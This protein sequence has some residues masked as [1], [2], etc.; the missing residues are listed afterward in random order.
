[1]PPSARS[2]WEFLVIVQTGGGPASN[3][4]REHKQKCSESQEASTSQGGQK[5]TTVSEVIYFRRFIQTL[6][7]LFQ[8]LFLYVFFSIYTTTNFQLIMQMS[9]GPQNNV[10]FLLPSSTF[11]YSE[12]CIRLSAGGSDLSHG[13]TAYC[14]GVHKRHNEC[15]RYKKTIVNGQMKW[16]LKRKNK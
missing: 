14:Q 8:L 3:W 15:L 4:T 11:H 6:N 7:N 2:R 12:C 16:K 13:N 1:M 9:E 10:Y 5:W